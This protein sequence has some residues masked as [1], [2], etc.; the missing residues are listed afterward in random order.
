M[1]IWKRIRAWKSE[2][3]IWIKKVWNWKR[4]WNLKNWKWKKSSWGKNRVRKIGSR[5]VE[6]ILNLVVGKKKRKLKIIYWTRVKKK[7]NSNLI[8]D[9]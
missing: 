9:W 1:E 3:L 4:T 8:V 2:C 5:K 6:I 7:R